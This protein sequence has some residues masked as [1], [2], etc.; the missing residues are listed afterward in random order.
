MTS[1]SLSQYMQTYRDHTLC[2]KW[3]PTDN[4]NSSCLQQK[5]KLVTAFVEQIT[6]LF[7]ELSYYWGFIE[8][9]GDIVYR[10][11]KGVLKGCLASRPHR[12]DDGNNLV[13]ICHCVQTLA[14]L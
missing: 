7:L 5:L 14:I 6:L 11:C 3:F 1:N 2:T 8:D 9:L 10:V 4:Q 12:H 13:D